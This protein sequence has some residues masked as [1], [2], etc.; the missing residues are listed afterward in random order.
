MVPVQ[1]ER[2]SLGGVSSARKRRSVA[3]G[4]IQ[5][6]HIECVCC[7]NVLDDFRSHFLIIKKSNARWLRCAMTKDTNHLNKCF[8][9]TILGISNI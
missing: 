9:C 6:N 8:K 1:T 2:R 4:S 5:L 3:G 7:K